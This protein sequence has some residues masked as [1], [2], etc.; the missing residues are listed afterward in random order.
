MVMA[1]LFRVNASVYKTAGRLNA[2]PSGSTLAASTFSLSLSLLSGAPVM[3]D[4]IPK[5]PWHQVTLSRDEATEYL[6][7]IGLPAAQTLQQP[8][9]LDLLARLLQSQLETIPKDTTPM[10]VAEQLWQPGSDP[11]TPISLTSALDNMPEGILAFDR[12]I[13]QRK[14][15]FCFAV[16]PT[17]SAFLRA[18]GFRVS[19]LVGRTF[20]NLNNDP[21]T[22]PDGFKWG[23]FTHGFEVVDWPG[24]EKRYLVDAAW[25]PWA[26]PVPYVPLFLVLA[27]EGS[28]PDP[29]N[30]IDQNRSRER[31]DRHR[32]EP[33]RSVPPRP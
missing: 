28:L 12:V 18:F 11:A 21:V 25:G 4:S 3:T 8:P 14:G 26:C 1:G 13:R 5:D 20:K 33:V 27:R 7:R 29:S 24:S 10:H 22:H 2:A 15:A 17:F 23:T 16:N 9:S 19:E 32:L 30:N 31:L 6:D